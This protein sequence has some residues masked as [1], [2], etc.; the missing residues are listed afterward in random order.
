MTNSIQT[1]LANE[2]AT[3][4]ASISI[5]DHV[6]ARTLINNTIDEVLEHRRYPAQSVRNNGNAAY[7]MFHGD[8]HVLYNGVMNGAGITLL[9]CEQIDALRFDVERVAKWGLNGFVTET[10]R[11]IADCIDFGSKSERD[12]W[13]L[14]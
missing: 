6:E 13:L 14:G 2:L 3:R 8:C 7:S 5:E 10:L 12:L 1:F 9:Q 4:R 11:Q